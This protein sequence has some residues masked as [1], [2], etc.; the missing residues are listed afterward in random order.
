MVDLPPPFTDELRTEENYL[1]S[2]NMQ[3]SKRGEPATLHDDPLEVYCGGSYLQDLQ[4]EAG[5]ELG[6][7]DSP[8][9]CKTI[10][11]N[12]TAFTVKNLVV[13]LRHFLL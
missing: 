4:Q 8:E 10:V 5:Q 12:S 1:H 7:G 2:G 6:S 9:T 13:N 11:S 3:Q